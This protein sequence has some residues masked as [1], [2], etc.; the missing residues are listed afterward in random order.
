MYIWAIKKVWEGIDMSRIRTIKPEIWTSEQVISCS[1]LSRLLFIGL[2]N[3]CD[4]NGVHP[5]SYIR[6]KAEV[7]PADDFDT[8][9]IK[10]WINELIN[11]EL[12]REYMIDNKSY[13]IVTGWKKHQR[14]DKPTYKH[15]L[16]QSDLTKI[17][18][19]STTI[20]RKLP[21]QLLIARD[22]VTESSDTEW[23][24]M[25]SNGKE[26]DICEVETSP[27]V[28]SHAA[29]LADM[30]EIFNHWQLVMNHP[31]AKIDAK[32][33][34]AIKKALDLGYS[35]DDLKLAIDGCASTPFNM[36][37]NDR[38]QVYDDITLIFRDADH[39]ERFMN[40]SSNAM[41]EFNSTDDFMAGVL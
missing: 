9:K 24:G 41:H 33:Q 23:K 27:C 3:F 11:N 35:I 2:W 1:P 21:E 38:R 14:I 20:R 32:R 25:E 5:A 28:V 30:N 19:N 40:N 37:E 15:P 18:D 16:P 31:R 13:W 6:I 10:N 22:Q 7:F 12:I 17:N 39:I 8:N 26:K 34:R 29:S 4:D 36:G